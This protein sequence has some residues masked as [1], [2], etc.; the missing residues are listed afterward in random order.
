MLR[1]ILGTMSASGTDMLIGHDIGHTPAP[2]VGLQN[3]D[4]QRRHALASVSTVNAVRVAGMVPTAGVVRSRRVGC[5]LQVLCADCLAHE[6]S[7][8]K[9]SCGAAAVARP[10]GP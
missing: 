5:R 9:S 7:T 8:R 10:W 1:V 4:Q 2:R 6:S 3:V